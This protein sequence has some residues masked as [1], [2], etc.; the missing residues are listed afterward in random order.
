M[1]VSESVLLSSLWSKLKT[2]PLYPYGTLVVH[3]HT[4]L[5]PLLPRIRNNNQLVK[6]S[7]ESKWKLTIRYGSGFTAESQILEHNEND[8]ST[9]RFEFGQNGCMF[10][11]GTITDLETDI[12]I[13]LNVIQNL[14]SES[15]V[16][17]P[18]TSVSAGLNDLT[19]FFARN[20]SD[21]GEGCIQ[22][23][24]VD[25]E[26]PTVVLGEAQWEVH[27]RVNIPL[28]CLES[29]SIRGY[30]H[31]YPPSQQSKQEYKYARPC[32]G[33]PGL[34]MSDPIGSLGFIE[35]SAIVFPRKFPSEL[36]YNFNPPEALWTLPSRFDLQA[37]EAA[38]LRAHHIL[39]TTPL[40]IR[41]FCHYKIL[42]SHFDRR[43]FIQ[44]GLTAMFWFLV[45]Y[46]FV[47]ST[48]FSF[49]IAAAALMTLVSY[50]YF[51]RS[52]APTRSTLLYQPSGGLK[53]WSGEI[54]DKLEAK[55]ISMAF[56]MKKTLHRLNQWQ[57][58]TG[59]DL[60]VPRTGTPQSHKRF[61]PS[62]QN[63]VPLAPSIFLHQGPRV[64]S[65]LPTLLGKTKIS[66][67]DPSAYVPWYPI[68]AEDVGEVDLFTLKHM[69][70]LVLEGVQVCI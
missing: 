2:L 51:A 33:Y 10:D 55:K 58:L 45:T 41:R 31:L 42:K 4:I 54:S 6:M 16:L 32:S 39:N 43:D 47:F 69:G 30:F 9:M 49:P 46:E 18:E 11:L 3:I 26:E 56:G 5:C 60:T 22:N 21:C 64:P 61:L 50:S 37:F 38:G 24:I 57:N 29:N 12:Q 28:Q 36:L 8:S 1:P 70:L 66:V 62:E 15:L 52:E 25:S 34:G 14:P 48:F 13:E 65:M 20:D 68:F 44:L 17:G 59:L 23:N 63:L 19:N 67:T 53:E 7:P 27:G 35:I 40:W